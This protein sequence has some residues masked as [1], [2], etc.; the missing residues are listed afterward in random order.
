MGLR[1]CNEAVMCL[2]Q[3]Y[4]PPTDQQ[5]KE[6]LTPLQVTNTDHSPNLC[7]L[8]P[9]LMG[10]SVVEGG[11]TL[12]W[13]AVEEKRLTTHYGHMWQEGRSSGAPPPTREI[14]NIAPSSAPV[15]PDPR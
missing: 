6:E 1:F 2:T 12:D 7:P 15:P 11:W 9:T 14:I 3:V 13:V 4:P 8:L 5:E 10:L